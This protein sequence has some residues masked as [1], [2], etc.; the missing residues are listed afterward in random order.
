MFPCLCSNITQRLSLATTVNIQQQRLHICIKV[1]M[2][3]KIRVVIAASLFAITGS[4]IVHDSKNF[5]R[6]LEDLNL[7]STIR[8]DAL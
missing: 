7:I 2:L 4:R 3:T 6:S 5:M 8:D 1:K